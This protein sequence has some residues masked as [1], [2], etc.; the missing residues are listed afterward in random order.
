[1]Q[2]PSNNGLEG[3]CA[4]ASDRITI[5]GNIRSNF[6]IDGIIMNMRHATISL[7]M[8]NCEQSVHGPGI[9][10]PQEAPAAFGQ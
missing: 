8:D 10:N 1:V 5:E 7:A 3:I 6:G 9:K 4:W 2:Q